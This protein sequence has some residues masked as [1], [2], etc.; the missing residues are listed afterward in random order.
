MKKRKE[1]SEEFLQL[2]KSLE[3]YLDPLSRLGLDLLN[4]KTI[5][6]LASK[7]EEGGSGSDKRYSIAGWAS[8]KDITTSPGFSS[9]SYDKAIQKELE[10]RG[11]DPQTF[12]DKDGYMP[13][14]VTYGGPGDKTPLMTLAHELRHV[15]DSYMTRKLGVDDDIEMSES[16]ITDP[17]GRAVERPLYG[18]PGVPPEPGNYLM[19]RII[20]KRI[21]E[22][23]GEP[24]PIS[25]YTEKQ[26][27]MGF[28]PERYKG[29]P[30][31]TPRETYSPKRVSESD[32]INH[33]AMEA[34]KQEF[35][36]RRGLSRVE[37]RKPEKEGIMSFFRNL[38]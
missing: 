38:L 8:L 25:K 16:G 1:P 7:W 34:A 11:T 17:L 33:P 29:D 12:L 36:E 14:Y 23:R 20:R 30:F 21:E 4:E 35:R 10:D 28:I 24:I 31:A 15:G 37:A 3:P 26:Q 27:K 32:M 9:S 5:F 19:D 13:A 6:K 18:V 22:K 2:K